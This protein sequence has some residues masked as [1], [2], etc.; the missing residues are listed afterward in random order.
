MAVHDNL[1][2]LSDAPV[3]ANPETAP[4]ATPE[5]AE[6]ASNAIE[7]TR[8]RIL[9]LLTDL[10]GASAFESSSLADQIR[11]QAAKLSVQKGVI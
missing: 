9:S 11:Q 1:T 2:V 6:A 3:V 7:V 8:K 10:E 4:S 5:V